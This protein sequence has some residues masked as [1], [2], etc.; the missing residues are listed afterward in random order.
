MAVSQLIFTIDE[1]LKAADKVRGQI[2]HVASS[3]FWHSL[4]GVDG[5]GKPTSKVLGWA[6][7]RSRDHVAELRKRFDET[8][9]H[10]RTGARFHSSFWPAKLLWLRKT[11][12]EAFGRTAQWLSLSDYVALKLFGNSSTSVSMASATGILDI[13]DCSWDRELAKFLKLKKSNLPEIATDRETFRLNNKFSRRW[14]RLANADWFPAI[15]DGAANNIGSG[16]VTKDRAALMVGTSGALR[17][18]YRGTAPKK[19]PGGLWCY[20]IDRERMIVGG[21]LSDGGGLYS[22]LKENL[23]LPANAEHA[24]SKRTPAGHGLTFM[25]FVAGERS[26]GYH[27]N[28]SGAVIG[29]TSTTDA[30]DIA[31]A[32]LE[33]VGYRFAEILEQLDGIVDIKEIV[34]SGGALRASK[35]WAQ[36]IADI[37]GRKLLL[38]EAPEASL[39]G[40]VLLTLETIGNI[41]SIEKISLRRSQVFEPNTDHSLAHTIARIR[42][43]DLYDRIINNH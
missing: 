28:A 3:C 7:N 19:I 15:G 38:V 12:P 31:Q 35:V 9:V 42:H 26:T 32:A 40:A 25:P 5:K 36:I 27:E 33:S 21:A 23:R 2:T 30:V 6:D 43:R 13:R 39:Y 14:K 41:E 4:V 18:A 24:I 20:R 11:Q 16:C 29:L 1:V 10:D 22:W 34:V 8:A 17:V 37:L